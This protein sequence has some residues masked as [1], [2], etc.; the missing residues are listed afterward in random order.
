MCTVLHE[1][2][3]DD[4]I[5]FVADWPRA[6]F[7][8]MENYISACIEFNLP[9]AMGDDQIS[10]YLDKL[11]E[12][13][14]AAS[15][16]EGHWGTLKRVCHAIGFKVVHKHEVHYKAVKADCREVKDNK[17]PVSR[18]L[19]IQLCEA[20]L[21]VFTGYT[22]CLARAI[23]I[24]AWAFS[25][26]ICEYCNVQVWKK[27]K[28]KFEENHNLRYSAIK[29]TKRGLTARFLSDKTSKAGDPIKRRSVFWKKLPDFAKPVMLA[30]R[31]LR[32]G[33][34]FFSKEDGTA[35]DRNDF[36]NILEPCLLHT[37]W[38]HL[39][40]TPHSFRQ[41]RASTEV[42]EGVS[43]EEIKHSCRWSATSKAFDAYC[44]TDLVMMR[45]DAIYREY[46][47][48]RKCWKT[49]RLSWITRH[50]VQTPGPA[51]KHAH[52]TMLS[53]EFPEQFEEM[54]ALN[55][56][57]E[58][59]PA[60]EC[61]VRMKAL[62]AD[63]ESGI[64]IKEQEKAEEQKQWKL[65]RR[66]MHAAACRRV[67]SSRKYDFFKSRSTLG[68]AGPSPSKNLSEF[69]NQAVYGEKADH[70]H[71]FSGKKSRISR[72]C[73]GKRQ[74]TGREDM[75]V[76]KKKTTS[77]S[78]QTGPVKRIGDC[79]TKVHRET[80]GWPRIMYKGTPTPVHED[81]IDLIP[82]IDYYQFDFRETMGNCKLVPVEGSREKVK[83]GKTWSI[84]SRR[85]VA[86]AIKRRISP[87]Y[88]KKNYNRA[89][90]VPF[91]IMRSHA[92]LVHHFT[93][94]YM[95]KGADGLPMEEKQPDP[96]VTD[97]EYE[98]RVLD[99]YAAK[100]EDYELFADENVTAEYRYRYRE[101]TDK[102]RKEGTSY[103]KA[104]PRAKKTEQNP[105]ASTAHSRHEELLLTKPL[106]VVVRRLSQHEI[107]KAVK[108]PVEDITN[109]I[110]FVD[111]LWTDEDE[112]SEDKWITNK[113]GE[114]ALEITLD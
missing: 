26:R 81:A 10:A 86:H 13:F 27:P 14:Y 24:S 11:D 90:G 66:E 70:S 67:T 96:D 108:K 30:Y 19:L 1:I 53:E 103:R 61:L 100:P 104:P 51:E 98:E 25:M 43:I 9:F 93:L 44:R 54:K 92:R 58:N 31:I 6:K 32:K 64:Y 2:G 84:K 71:F 102:N 46:P 57:P 20:A 12:A 89:A 72:T 37:G 107:E 29:V 97:D 7:R 22:A 35:L 110:E 83:E 36:L 41:G 91:F 21:V 49:K 101:T 99:N 78:S 87:R 88:R 82:K 73:P 48:S 3:I 8:A 63:R 75:A 45:P 55:E 16:L 65:R 18:E 59:Y 38:C 56:L 50:F 106:S 68:L 39:A 60:P 114:L 15:T 40:V 33:T 62:Q 113:Q 76:G 74:H 17:L 4:V 42:N 109:K 79:T 105:Q 34:N 111:N 23:F 28:D 112:H 52:H 5:P 95:V 69:I 80:D 94:E 77:R 85:C 47:Q